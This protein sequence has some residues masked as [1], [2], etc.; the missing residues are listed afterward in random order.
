VAHIVCY[1]QGV[2]LFY[3][4]PE[5]LKQMST[6]AELAELAVM[7]LNSFA[8][9]FKDVISISTFLFLLPIFCQYNM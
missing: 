1:Y 3:C 5:M 9:H 8:C 6:S 4:E 2:K 7:A